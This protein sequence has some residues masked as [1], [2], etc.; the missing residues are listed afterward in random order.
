MLLRR[1]NINY[2]FYK[3]AAA[4]YNNLLSQPYTNQITL[5]R[6]LS[7]K[8]C[9]FAKARNSANESTKANRRV[10][11]A[12]YNSVNSTMN[13]CSISPKKIFS[14]FLKLMKN[15]QFTPTPHLL[16]NNV[17]IHEPQQK[18]EL[19]NTFVASKSNVH[20]ANDDPPNLQPLLDIPI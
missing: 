12:F 9:A 13:N 18:S 4:D 15:N 8:K 6:Y 1:K 19:F 11:F 17:T 10:K 20:G 5:T 3:K 2:Q 16:E 14:I 7:K